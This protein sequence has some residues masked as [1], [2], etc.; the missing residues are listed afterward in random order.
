M[1]VLCIVFFCFNDI[2][3]ATDS[4]VE[5]NTNNEKYVSITETND[6]VVNVSILKIV[7][8]HIEF[9]LLLSNVSLLKL[10]IH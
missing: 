8:Y 9:L 6:T 7:I 10:L 1:R 4:I 2:F 3:I 5:K